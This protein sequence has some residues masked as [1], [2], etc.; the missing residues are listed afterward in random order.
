[1]EINWFTVVAQV[2]NFLILVWLLQK[3]LYHPILKAIDDREK[4]IVDQIND[5]E[6]KK[7]EAKAEREEFRLKNEKF[8]QEKKDLMT[9]AVSE[10]KSER[11]KLEEDARKEAADLRTKQQ[12]SLQDLAT[13]HDQQLVQKTQDEVFAIASKV[14]RELSSQSLEE[15][16][17]DTFIQRI[18]ALK[19]S[20]K[21]QFRDAFATNGNLPKAKQES[22]IIRSAFDLTKKLQTKITGAVE[23]ILPGE[24]SFEYKTTPELISGIELSLHGYK[25]AW[26]ISAYLASMEQTIAESATSKP[27]EKSA[28]EEHAPE[29][30]K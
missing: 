11:E 26:S 16:A 10:V 22:M 24:I 27:K 5:A 19:E 8:D 29:P 28:K 6:A 14:L 2:I 21:K 23:G 7:T 17:V 12:K 20:E 9:K 4:K 1:M 3:F 25:L 13:S 15:Q 30:V 18:N